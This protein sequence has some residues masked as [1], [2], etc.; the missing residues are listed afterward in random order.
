MSFMAFTRRVAFEIKPYQD[1]FLEVLSQTLEQVV[2]LSRQR[3]CQMPP[4]LVLV[5]DN[6]VAGV[7]NNFGLRFLA[8]LVAQNLFRS[9]TLFS[10]MVGHTHEEI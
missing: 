4:H 9:T 10:L 8:Y 7:K 1:H 6:T 2:Q 5:A 3:S